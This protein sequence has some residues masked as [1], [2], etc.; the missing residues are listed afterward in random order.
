MESSCQRISWWLL[1]VGTRKFWLYVFSLVGMETKER[2][3][4]DERHGKTPP[5]SMQ[6]GTIRL[7]GYT[8]NGREP[9]GLSVNKV[10]HLLIGMMEQK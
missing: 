9:R 8:V 10:I 2:T 4:G 3:V 5:L 6:G 1:N 7:Y